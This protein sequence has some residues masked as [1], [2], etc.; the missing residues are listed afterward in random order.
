MPAVTGK[1]KWAQFSK[2]YANT[3]FNDS[4]STNGQNENGN[5]TWGRDQKHYCLSIVGQDGKPHTIG[6]MEAFDETESTNSDFID[7]ACTDQLEWELGTPRWS[8]SLQRMQPRGFDM[9][10]LMRLIY[11]GINV[12][13]WRYL[14]FILQG[15]FQY[16]NPTAV[17]SAG[18]PYIYEAAS[19]TYHKCFVQTYRNI[20]VPGTRGKMREEVSIV[21]SGVTFTENGVKKW[22]TNPFVWGGQ[23]FTSVSGS[24]SGSQNAGNPFANT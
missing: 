23:F 9:R 4:A 10:Q 15:D 22:E 12:V 1:T 18:N 2:N 11:P 21:G 6:L 8:F 5:V 17:D 24:P 19:W 14:P 13:D 3:A 7:V 20:P 16:M